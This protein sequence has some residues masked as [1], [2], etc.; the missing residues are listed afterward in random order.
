MLEHEHSLRPRWIRM[1][2]PRV[3]L[4]NTRGEPC[5]SSRI[6]GASRS[7]NLVGTPMEMG[8]FLRIAIGLSAVSQAAARSGLH[9]QGLKPANV[10]M[11]PA[12][13]RFW[14]M[15]LGS[16]SIA[17]RAPVGE[18]PEF[19]AERSPYMAP[20]QTGRMN[21]SIDSRVISMP[22]GSRFTKC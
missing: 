19:I 3:E 4:S 1:A 22:W 9:P 2:V 12:L 20:E 6:P 16:P 18:P 5:L 8:R 17:A 13:A 10:M 11:S 7:I 14:L 21:R 15:G